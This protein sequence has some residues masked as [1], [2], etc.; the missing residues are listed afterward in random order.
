MSIL[1]KDLFVKTIIN[2]KENIDPNNIHNKQNIDEK[3]LLKLKKRL[4]NKCSKYGYIQRDSM[5]LIDRNMGEI[6]SSQFNGKLVYNVKLEVIIC[7]PSKNDIVSCKVI[8]KNKIGILCQSD[9]LVIILSKDYHN[10]N[11]EFKNIQKDDIIHVKIIDYKYK[12]S[13]NQIQEVGALV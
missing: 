12:Y 8:A 7:S 4:G 3:L 10:D 9:P 6:I 1:E 13:D 11:T 5:K 2:T